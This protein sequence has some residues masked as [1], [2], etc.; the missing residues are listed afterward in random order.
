M[1]NLIIYDLNR[2]GVCHLGRG[3][4]LWN[5]GDFKRRRNIM[6]LQDTT[7]GRAKRVLNLAR[8]DYFQPELVIVF[9]NAYGGPKSNNSVCISIKEQQLGIKFTLIDW[10][11]GILMSAKTVSLCVLVYTFRA[12]LPLQGGRGQGIISDNTFPSPCGVVVLVVDYVIRYL[13][14]MYIIIKNTG[15]LFYYNSKEVRWVYC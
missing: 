11:W 3:V 6:K 5:R 4:Y 8:D 10:P 1:R 9:W 7:W 2:R 15:Q 13:N 14:Y 12:G